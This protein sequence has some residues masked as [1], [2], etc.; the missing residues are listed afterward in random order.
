MTNK[1]MFK[2]DLEP[3]FVKPKDVLPIVMEELNALDAPL[4]PQVEHTCDIFTRQFSKTADRL[5]ITADR[6]Q[7][8]VNDLREKANNIRAAATSLPQDIKDWVLT[9][10]SYNADASFYDPI[11]K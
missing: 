7:K 2:K 10:R 8:M 5:D 1:N 6:L 4:H 11:L 3:H 9:E